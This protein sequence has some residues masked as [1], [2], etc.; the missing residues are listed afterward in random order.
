MASK[1]SPRVWMISALTPL[2]RIASLAQLTPSSVT[3]YEVGGGGGE[4]GKGGGP[5]GGGNS[6]SDCGGTLGDGAGPRQIERMCGTM[7]GM[8]VAHAGS[9]SSG[10]AK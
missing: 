6:G 10:S 5:G 2:A 8:A 1:Q 3:T 7:E 4:G 9:P